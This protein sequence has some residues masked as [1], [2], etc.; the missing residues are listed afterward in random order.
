MICR[1]NERIPIVAYH[2]IILFNPKILITLKG[3][4]LFKM[5]FICILNSLT[6]ESGVEWGANAQGTRLTL[7]LCFYYRSQKTASF[8]VTY[9]P[10]T[11]V[12]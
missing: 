6:R 9:N 7:K 4:N 5:C 11:A 10:Q 2:I 3:F 8:N 12:S 1:V